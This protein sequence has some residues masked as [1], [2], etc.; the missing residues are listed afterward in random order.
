MRKSK[1]FRILALVIIPVV[2]A[3]ALGFIIAGNQGKDTDPTVSTTTSSIHVGAPT[4][5]TDP[6]PSI[7]SEAP[8]TPTDP[9][10]PTGSD[11]IPDD[12]TGLTPEEPTEPAVPLVF[13]ENG[14]PARTLVPTSA[15]GY[16]VWRDVYITNTSD[17]GFDA[18]LFDGSFAAA[19]PEIS[20]RS[21][22]ALISS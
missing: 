2:L 17:R 6:D 5:P 14:V 13:A 7:G 3:V 9:D 8:S 21:Q 15:E 18:S 16:V 4:D 10:V 12:D 11:E 20:P 19:L 1:L 22:A